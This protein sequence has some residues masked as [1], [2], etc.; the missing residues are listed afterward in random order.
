MSIIIAEL[1]T[2]QSTGV[3]SIVNLGISCGKAG[4]SYVKLQLGLD[5]LYEDNS[6]NYSLIKDN[7]IDLDSARHIFKEF[8]KHKI[9]FTASCW[10]EKSLDFMLEFNPDF[11]KVGSG[12]ATYIPL[13]EKI[14]KSG[15][16]S[17]LSVGMCSKQEID[18]AIGALKNVASIMVC[19]VNYPCDKIDVNLSRM[20]T[21]YNAYVKSGLADS[22]G[23]SNHSLDW[24]VPALAVMNGAKYIELHIS[25][26]NSFGI[27]IGDMIN[28][29]RF[30]EGYYYDI[31]FYD[32]LL[33]YGS[34]DLG[35]LTC[36]LPWINKARR[37]PETW[38]RV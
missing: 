31:N 8:T 3:D 20:S 17:I 21:I 2:A 16:K 33:I 25:N 4:A 13:L 35:V 15:V 37:N 28:F 10:S 1:G 22:V 12:D 5:E 23:F 19:T 14:G 32:A 7:V 34:P 26:G 24:K 30:S 36:E 11:I 6:P 9:K 38:K 29:C 18:S 27:P